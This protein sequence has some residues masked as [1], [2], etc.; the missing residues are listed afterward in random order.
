MQ[1]CFTKEKKKEVGGSFSSG[2]IFDEDI[3]E[4]VIDFLFGNYDRNV[5]MM[6]IGREHKETVNSLALLNG[7]I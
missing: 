2:N 5:R 6:T 3:S 1:F 4:M 7:T